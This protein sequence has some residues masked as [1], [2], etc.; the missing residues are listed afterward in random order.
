YLSMEI[1]KS[2]PVVGG[3][4]VMALAPASIV[5]IIVSSVGP[6]VAT[7]GTS[8]N[9]SLI[10]LTMLAVFAAPETFRM[11]APASNL[12]LISVFSDTTVTIMGISIILRIAIMVSLGVGALTT[13]PIAPLNSA[14]RAKLTTLLPL[15]NPPPTPQKTGTSAT[16]VIA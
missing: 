13:T 2:S 15:V 7:I 3:V 16:M 10:C 5:A 4:Y 14:S 1:L 11:V 9:S 6:P 12:D 8:G